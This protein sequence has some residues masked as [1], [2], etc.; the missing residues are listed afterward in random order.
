MHGLSE[1]TYKQILQV[2]NKYADKK[3]KLFGS[4]AIDKAKSNSDIDIAVLD[5]V[6]EKEMINIQ[7]DF[8]LLDIPYTIDLVFIEEILKSGLQDAIL[9]EGVDF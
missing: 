3:F 5:V 1:E 6:E 2:I 4:R 8:D 7:N 9:R